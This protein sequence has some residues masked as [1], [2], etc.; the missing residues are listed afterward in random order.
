MFSCNF[1]PVFCFYLVLYCITTHTKHNFIPI[2]ILEMKYYVV[3]S[4]ALSCGELFSIF[5]LYFK[6]LDCVTGIEVAYHV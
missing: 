6:Q 3:E 5:M 4:G 2:I 1:L